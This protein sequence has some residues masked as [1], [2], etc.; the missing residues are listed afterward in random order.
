M[1]TTT[2]IFNNHN[3]IALILL[4]NEQIYHNSSSHA[5]D[6]FYNIFLAQ[7]SKGL[8]CLPRSC[9][10]V[11]VRNLPKPFQRHET[12]EI[13]GDIEQIIICLLVILGLMAL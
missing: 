1:A 12:A 11:N 9:L 10:A 3:F 7:R 5:E 8:N 6:L 13:L 2:K 4:I